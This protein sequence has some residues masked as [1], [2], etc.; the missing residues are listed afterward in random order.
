MR[1]K[2][3]SRTRRTRRRAAGVDTESAPVTEI[4]EALEYTTWIQRPRSGRCRIEMSPFPDLEFAVENDRLVDIEKINFVRALSGVLEEQEK[5]LKHQRL[6]LNHLLTPRIE[7]HFALWRGRLE[8]E[9]AA[10]EEQCE[11]VD[12]HTGKTGNQILE[13]IPEWHRRMLDVIRV[14]VR[15]ME[16][17]S[18]IIKDVYGLG[19]LREFELKRKLIPLSQAHR[20]QQKHIKAQLELMGFQ[21]RLYGFADNDQLREIDRLVAEF[22]QLVRTPPSHESF[23]ESRLEWLDPWTSLLVDGG[24]LSEHIRFQDEDFGVGK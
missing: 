7:R 21:H 17:K 4:A 8:D 10:V 16:D 24:D 19:T 5:A 1:F 14:S 11:L 15:Q 23:S 6:I 12:E 18:T 13:L 3:I 22:E 20:N 9:T 2:W